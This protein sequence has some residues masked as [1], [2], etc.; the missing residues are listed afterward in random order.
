MVGAF[1]LAATPI[2]AQEPAPPPKE[3]APPAP[4][5]AP[6]PAPAT[7]TIAQ[8]PVT[9]VTIAFDDKAKA[10][11][12]VKFLFTPTGGQAKE[13]RVTVAK[14][15]KGNDVAK[16]TLKEFKVTLGDTYK[17]DGG[18]DSITIKSKSKEQTFVLSISEQQVT[19]LSVRLK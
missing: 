4:A 9:K 15:M 16:D 13:I 7:A 1:I 3:P 10:N 14:G 11:G 19:G 6:T 12:E 8:T 18:G 17:I 5:P 2:L